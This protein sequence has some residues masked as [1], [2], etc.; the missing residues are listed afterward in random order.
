MNRWRSIYSA[1]FCLALALL[2]ACDGHIYLRDGS[3]DGDTFYLP[4][5]VHD[6]D[7]PVLQSWVAYSLSRSVCQLEGGG[8][9][10]GRR[11][12]FDCELLARSIL[13]EQWLQFSAEASDSDSTAAAGAV[14][15]DTLARVHSAGFLPE[16]IWHYL[17]RPA[18]QMPADL[19]TQAFARWR[20]E[21]LPAD[22][23]PL[24]RL[25]GFWG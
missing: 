11:Q 4:P 2:S 23:R 12:S 1:C 9:N 13:V 24:T 5:Q 15:L 20:R 18:W 7:D 3:T 25:I 6:N 19:R 10:P 22:H 14:Y 16:Y 21:Q 8:E 17:R